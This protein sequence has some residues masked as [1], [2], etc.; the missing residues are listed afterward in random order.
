MCFPATPTHSHGRGVT[1]CCET[2][3]AKL[4]DALGDLV[5]CLHFV[6]IPCLAGTLGQ[7]VQGL[8]V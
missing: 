1:S 3:S 4:N 5:T 6:Q 8:A 7:T 2:V